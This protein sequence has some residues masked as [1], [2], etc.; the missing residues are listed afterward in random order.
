MLSRGSLAFPQLTRLSAL[1]AAT[2]YS[3]LVILSLHSLLYHSESEVNGRLV[4]LYEMNQ[5]GIERR[6]RGGWYVEMAKEWNESACLDAVVELMWKEGMQRRED[7]EAVLS[8]AMYEKQESDDRD[9]A[10]YEA[11]GR[12]IP[13]SLRQKGKRIDNSTDGERSALRTFLAVQLTACF[14]APVSQERGQESPKESVRG[15]V[16][17]HRHSRIATLAQFARDQ[18]GR[19]TPPEH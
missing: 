15:R 10:A 19:G 5:V 12:P 13:D 4:E 8:K 14:L 11:Q 18:V 16:H 3:S 1:P 6:M 7:L 9:R 17:F 2:I